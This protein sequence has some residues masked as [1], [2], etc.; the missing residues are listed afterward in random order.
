MGKA[1]SKYLDGQWGCHQGKTN[2]VLKLSINAT[3][4]WDRAAYSCSTPSGD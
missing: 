4:L 2:L 3:V 1:R